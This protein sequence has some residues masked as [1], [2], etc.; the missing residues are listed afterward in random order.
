M[1]RAIYAVMIATFFP[2]GILLAAGPFDGDWKGS[3]RFKKGCPT[4]EM[5]LKI[6]DGA[7]TGER[8]IAGGNPGKLGG[9]VAPDGKLVG[10]HGRLTGEFSGN[11]AT[12][13]FHT[14]EKSCSDFTFMLDKVK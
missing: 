6:A 8:I 5:T 7:V 9:H 2:A 14:D 3:S 1:R 12:V 13:L 11:S 4:E 10:N